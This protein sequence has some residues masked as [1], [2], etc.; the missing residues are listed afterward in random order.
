[1][2]RIFIVFFLLAGA[3]LW[4][5]NPLEKHILASK[6]AVDSIVAAQ[7]AYLLKQLSSVEDL[8]EQQKI[9]EEQAQQMKKD[10][11]ER[12]KQRTQQLIYAQAQT[13]QGQ[14][15]KELKA[16]PADSLKV[17]SD[18]LASSSEAYQK[19]VAQVDSLAQ[20]QEAN[21]YIR[22]YINRGDV[23]LPY[24]ALG[25]LNLS[26]AEHFG[27]KRL[28]PLGSKSFELGLYTNFRLKK[29]D[30]LLHL[31][32]GV[33][34]LYENFKIRG[35]YYYDRQA[36]NTQLTPYDSELTKSK[37]RA[38]YLIIPIDIEWDF[39]KDKVH[40]NVSYFQTHENLYLGVGAFVGL[41]LDSSQKINYQQQ[42]DVYKTIIRKDLYTNLWTYGISAHIGVKGWSLY[43]R[44]SLAP[45]FTNN[46]KG[47][48]PFMIGIRAGR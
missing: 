13:L 38:H 7:K 36:G 15:D 40:R 9:S 30:N 6:Y 48:Y 25:V 39:S 23:Y 11:K 42:G 5:Q 10:F 3:T 21:K 45:L 18:T 8:L 24:L 41:L 32:F 26:S 44:Y 33:S 46:P 14:L 17:T 12:S 1:M 37:F 19:A 35:N 4:A 28:S 27:D 22:R 16:L 2:K 31:N 29:N 34:W 20:R 43:G 47:E